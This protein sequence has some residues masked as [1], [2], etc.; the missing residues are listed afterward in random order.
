MGESTTTKT[1][2]KTDEL[3]DTLHAGIEALTTTETWTAWLA[4]A[5]RFHTY[6][7][8]NQI[9]IWTQNPDA[10]R[11]AGYRAWT[12]LGRQVRRGEKGLRILAPC[13]YNTTDDTTGEETRVVRGFRSVAVFDIS[14]TDGD[15]LP[16]APVRT[17]TGT[18]PNLFRH[19]LAALIRAEGFTC[20]RGPM[21]NGHAQANGLTDWGTR[22]VTVR[23]DLTDAQ[24]AKTTA[25]ELAHVLL[26]QPGTRSTWG[27]PPTDRGTR[28]IEAESVAYLV[29]AHA[30][31]D[32]S[33]YSFGYVAGWASGDLD[34][35]RAT[36][37]RVTT[38]S[39]AVIERLDA[40]TSNSEAAA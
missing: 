26:H 3:L 18:A 7:L 17:L 15:P 33:D 35:I 4:I 5:A 9:L 34:A 21:P 22:T 37:E 38:C 31:L 39:H 11:V 40:T 20:T 14:Q 27:T 30:G 16:E 25:H 13:T 2:T 12:R 36:A 19:Q 1:K 32:A 28:E 10:T 24:A 23:D 29:C 8:N 6:S